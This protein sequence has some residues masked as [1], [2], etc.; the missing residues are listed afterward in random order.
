MNPHKLIC[1]LLMALLVSACSPGTGEFSEPVQDN[2]DNN[3]DNTEVS[4][5]S[6]QETIFTPICSQCHFGSRAPRG[7]RLDSEALAYDNLVNIVAEGNSSFLRVEPENADDSFL[8]MKILGD[9]IAGQRM[10]LGL[11]PLT[12]S[13]INL[14]RQWINQGALP[15]DNAKDFKISSF[16][17]LASQNLL[18]LKIIF[19]QRIFEKD[20]F[21]QDIS[22]HNVRIYNVTSAG[23]RTIVSKY[24]VKRLSTNQ[25]EVK[26]D[27]SNLR[28]KSIEIHLSDNTALPL[29]STSGQTLLKTQLQHQDNHYGYFIKVQ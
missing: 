4:L 5:T 20:L 21:E 2:D 12:S 16:K 11:S 6:I 8:M 18:Q 14:I 19:N 1:G 3:P 10:P 9:P 28:S 17:V 22:K 13:E 23:E 7:L 26:I 27:T 29:H 15:S 25:I 24:G